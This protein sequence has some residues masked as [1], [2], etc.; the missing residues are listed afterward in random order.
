MY[1]SESGEYQL[2]ESNL[3][4]TVREGAISPGKQPSTTDGTDY[5][6]AIS[7]YPY[8]EETT[9]HQFWSYDPY[10]WRSFKITYS[11]TN[12]FKQTAANMGVTVT[13]T[14]SAY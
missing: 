13:P 11:A 3:V 12:I 4:N 8:A 9:Q 7:F 5:Y 2:E 10:P 14:L 1:L 6:F